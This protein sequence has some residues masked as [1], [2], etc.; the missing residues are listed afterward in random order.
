[1]QEL[2]TQ[3]IDSV[4]GGTTQAQVL[5]Y[6]AAVT[7]VGA[8]ALFAVGSPLLVAGAS[9]FA[10]TSAAMWVGS[11]ALDMGWRWKGNSERSEASNTKG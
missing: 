1:M 3:E 10:I 2:S 7:A 9:A 4:S 8:A 6:G 11:A 5:N